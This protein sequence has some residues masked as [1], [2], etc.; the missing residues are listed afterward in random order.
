MI[1]KVQGYTGFNG[2]KNVKPHKVAR[3]VVN[4]EQ[5]TPKGLSSPIR[6]EDAIDDLVKAAEVRFDNSNSS[7]RLTAMFFSAGT[8]TAALD[9]GFSR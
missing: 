4:M 1:T 8:V 9:L 3:K 5:K 6:R 7:E 2:I